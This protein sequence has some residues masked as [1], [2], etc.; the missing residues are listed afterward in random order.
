[1]EV[2]RR[3]G[4]LCWLGIGQFRRLPGDRSRIDE[5]MKQAGRAYSLVYR[6]VTA[7][8]PCDLRSDTINK[9]CDTCRLALA[10]LLLYALFVAVS[11]KQQIIGYLLSDVLFLLSFS[12]VLCVVVSIFNFLCK[13]KSTILKS[14]VTRRRPTLGTQRQHNTFLNIL[15]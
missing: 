8:K 3:Q 10:P 13:S 6:T 7:Y 1:M 14:F 12:A 11:T 2:D 5:D 4:P 15:F 9:P